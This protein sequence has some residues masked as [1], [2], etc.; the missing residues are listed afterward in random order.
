MAKG[1]G[2]DLIRFVTGARHPPFGNRN[3]IFTVAYDLSRAG[4]LPTY[5][6]EELDELLKWFEDHLPIP[7][8]FTVSKHPR[9]EETAISWIRASAH[10]HVVQLRRLVLLVGAAGFPI[11]ELRTRRP[12]YVVYEDDHQVVAFP[13]SDTPS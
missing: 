6:H 1:Q 7:E 5:E 13:F 10:D 11:D 3:G 8:T 9:A 12:G 2:G 4:R